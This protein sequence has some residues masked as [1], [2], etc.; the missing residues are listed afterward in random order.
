MIIY[1]L[2]YKV[3]DNNK[4]IRGIHKFNNFKIFI[5]T[6]CKLPDDITLK[7]LILITFI[8]TDDGKLYPKIFFRRIIISSIKY[9]QCQHILA[10]FLVQI[11]NRYGGDIETCLVFLYFKS[12]YKKFM[13]LIHSSSFY[14]FN[15]T[16]KLGG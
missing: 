3:I 7:N 2:K 9:Y 1:Q 10:A 14:S 11:K 4:E 12:M 8:I 15:S 6:Y 16:R 13:E 5:D